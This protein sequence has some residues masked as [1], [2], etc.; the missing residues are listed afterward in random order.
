MHLKRPAPTIYNLH[1]TI[2][3]PALRLVL[4]YQKH[5]RVI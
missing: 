3:S 1:E 2:N 4:I 5:N